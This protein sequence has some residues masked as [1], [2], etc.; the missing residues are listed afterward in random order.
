[1]AL[2]NRHPGL[3]VGLDISYVLGNAI[4]TRVDDYLQELAH[5]GLAVRWMDDM[6][7]GVTSSTNGWGAIEEL[8]EGPLRALHLRLHPRKTEVVPA[9][10]WQPKESSVVYLGNTDLVDEFP[11]HRLKEMIA[12]AHGAVPREQ[13]KGIVRALQQLELDPE[14]EAEFLCDHAAELT[15]ASHDVNQRLDALLGGSFPARFT[16]RLLASCRCTPAG[17][18]WEGEVAEQLLHLDRSTVGVGSSG[19]THLLDLVADRNRGER[20]RVAAGW[21]L[22]RRA[23]DHDR[24]VLERLNEMSVPAARGAVAAAHLAGAKLTNFHYHQAGLTHAS[25]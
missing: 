5:E 14:N 10:E 13:A 1:M 17:S 18:A 4:L 7:L 6:A 8:A 12:S 15:L 3:P 25:R 24:R 22:A 11:E 20:A 16:E 2:Q 21:V 23:G 19:R 9:S